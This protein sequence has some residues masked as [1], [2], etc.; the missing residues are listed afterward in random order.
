MRDRTAY[1]I[2]GERRWFWRDDEF[3]GR[4]QRNGNRKGIWR[5]RGTHPPRP[6]GGPPRRAKT[7]A[8]TNN[9]SRDRWAA[10]SAQTHAMLCYAGRTAVQTSATALVLQRVP[11]RGLGRAVSQLSSLMFAFRRCVSPP[12]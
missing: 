3:E 1:K 4:S 2:E 11:G 9:W 12:V 10:T 5:E 6:E 7:R 8:H